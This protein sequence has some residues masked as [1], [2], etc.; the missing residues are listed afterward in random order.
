M[1]FREYRGPRG[2]GK[3]RKSVVKREN[4]YKNSFST[5]GTLVYEKE[6]KKVLSRRILSWR[7]VYISSQAF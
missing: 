4:M 1:D 5:G 3:R 6:R 7:P 2:K